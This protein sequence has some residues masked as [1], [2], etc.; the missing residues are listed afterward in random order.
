MENKR[1]ELLHELL[2]A[3]SKVNDNAELKKALNKY[4]DLS[5]VCANKAMYVLL[6]DIENI[7]RQLICL[8]SS[9]ASDK[10]PTL[11]EQEQKELDEVNRV[12][13]ENAFNYHFQP[14]VNTVDGDIY[15]FEALMRPI[16][17]LCPSPFHIIKYAK[18]GDR[19]N[20]IERATF[21]NV[22]GIIDSK[23]DDFGSRRIFINSIPK[24]KLSEE[25]FEAV[26]ALMKKHSDKVIVEMTEESEL[27]DAELDKI[28]QIYLDM[29]V[30]M[31]IDDYGTGYSN[32]QNL[33]RYMPNYVKIDRSLISS[34]H[35]DEKK[36]HFVR[37]IIE[38][39]HENN[40]MAL[41]EGVETYDELHTVILLGVDLIQGYYTGKP[42]AELPDSIPH[43][44]RQEIKR[45]RREREDGKKLQIYTAANSERIF[46]DKLAK[47]D[48]KCILVGKNGNGDISVVCSPGLDTKI[49]IAV[50]DGFSGSI[51]LENSIL[52]NI[53][54]RP[55][56][57]IGEN[58]DVRLILA[59]TNHLK[60]G[61][62]RVPESSRFICS[63]DGNLSIYIDGSAYYGI[64]NDDESRHGELIFEQGVTIENYSPS[65]VCIGSGL[66]G[67]IS[68]VSGQFILNMSGYLGVGIGAL[69]S[70]TDLD[71]F[72]CDITMDLA[73]TF[74]VGIGSLENNCRL[75]VQHSALKLFLS[76]NNVVG[77]GT[78]SGQECD[79][80]VS[81]ASII[82]NIAADNCSAVAALNGRT[83]FKLSK[84]GMHITVKG[85][86]AFA[87]GGFG[88]SKLQLTNSDSSINLA[89]NTDYSKYISEEDISITGGR[90]RFTVNDV[91][92]KNE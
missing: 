69:K 73:L 68:I 12:I 72:A 41:A 51:T 33:L 44:I 23:T 85:D 60:K 90:S 46:L 27:N 67:K 80:S 21:L 63:G 6:K 37:D 25:D 65:G 70:D 61:G 82:V 35:E 78:V 57:D 75:Y 15:S 28:R 74:G 58:C 89:T 54:N 52:S 53:K 1:L 92:M 81:E 76:G 16:S 9:A 38:F 62:I 24:T 84:A 88:A 20:D 64:G 50:A 56:I 71:L 17:S 18:L 8:R 36:R 19:L 34:I 77:V 30:D 11:S 3:V 86:N 47:E 32:I 42:S 7:G 26:C 10:A 39:C 31:A 83:S 29:G 48:Y 49:H 66:G 13:D 91:I 43:E 2:S 5:E 4:A 59:G 14:I 79:I 55:C 40:I 22:L 87:L 45:C